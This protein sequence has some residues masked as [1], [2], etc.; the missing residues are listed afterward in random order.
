[1]D[2][3]DEV[4]DQNMNI[5]GEDEEDLDGDEM[6]ANIGPE[7]EPEGDL[8]HYD[9]NT[10]EILDPEQVRAGEID[11][12][13]RFK[14]IGVY[15]YIIEKMLYEIRRINKGSKVRCRLVAQE[16]GFGKREDELFV[17]TPSLC[18]VKLILSR[19]MSR[20][21]INV[22]VIDVK[23]AFLYGQMTRN[24]Y[25][26]LP[27]R[28]PQARAGR[29]VGKLVKAMYG[30]RDAPKIWQREVEMTMIEMGCKSSVLHPAVYAHG[31]RSLEIV[32]H[33]DDFLCTGTDED[34]QW[35]LSKMEKKYEVTATFAEKRG[36]REIR[37][38]NRL[39]NWDD[40]GDSIT[41]QGDPKHA[42][43]L[44]KE[45][46]MEK[47]NP[48]VTPMVND[49]V[50]FMNKDNH[51]LNEEDSRKVR[52]AIARI[53]F[54][55]QD[56]PDLSVTSRVLSQ[57]MANPKVSTEMAV[58]R[59]IRYLR[60]RPVCSATFQRQQDPVLRVY[61]GS[62]WANEEKSRKSVS[63]GCL[64]HGMHCIGHW[65]KL[66]N[67]IALSSGEAEL[68]SAV[69]GLSELLAI[70]QLMEE[71]MGGGGIPVELM[72][73]ANACRGILL[74]KGA[75]RIK[76]LAT[77]QLWSQEAIIERNVRVLKIPRDKNPSDLLTH[78]TTKVNQGKFLKMMNYAHDSETE[79]KE[80]GQEGKLADSKP[81]GG[82]T[83]VKLNPWEGKPSLIQTRHVQEIVC[84]LS[85]IWDHEEGGPQRQLKRS[86]DECYIIK[87]KE[88]KDCQL[89]DGCKVK[90][91]KTTSRTRVHHQRSSSECSW[92]RLNICGLSALSWPRNKCPSFHVACVV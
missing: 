34:L 2:G 8:I 81:V 57:H 92:A 65:S 24:I 4:M 14:Q 46:K 80:E 36:V 17:G 48:V 1:M 77:K 60:G 39:I 23:C 88:E 51:N 49:M 16:L 68:N 53:N 69:K 3:E 74:R 19:M 18:I 30:T 64:M 9:Q 38:L 66:Q 22:L 20:P 29:Y 84:P 90:G 33:V 62:D 79:M 76:H 71:V 85:E 56:R 35:F 7:E 82:K 43:L 25:I 31:E 87:G 12:M 75:G 83:Y 67:N 61:V 6:I 50:D 37:Y 11:E 40:D 63:G 86:N 52:R 15:Q 78:L 32:T 5:G 58:K 54:M 42:K 59:V 41:I 13:N 27:Q 10:G 91:G 44:F 70:S 28:D 26:E 72:T 73:D 55:A 21:N 45:W 47:A 89:N